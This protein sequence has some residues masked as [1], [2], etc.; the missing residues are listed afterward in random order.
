MT[1]VWT[2]K[3][4][5]CSHLVMTRS[6]CYPAHTHTLMHKETFTH[7]IKLLFFHTAIYPNKL[8]A[9]SI[10]QMKSQLVPTMQIKATQSI[11]HYT[12]HYKPLAHFKTPAT[13]NQS[14]HVGE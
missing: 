3:Q 13:N 6:R 14:Y 1:A 7:S 12:Y 11:L 2:Q 5:K 9:A 8:G 4:R 10:P